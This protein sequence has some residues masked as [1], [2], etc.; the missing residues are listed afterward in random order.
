MDIITGYLGEAHVTAEQDR[1]VNIGVVGD[2]SYVMPAGQRLAAEVQT[3]N[4]VRIRDGVLIHQGCAASIKKNT[5][6]TVTIA[7]G[8]QGM[9][10]IDLIVARYQRNVETGVESLDLIALQGTPAESDPAVP[11]HTEGDIQAGDAVA[12][13]P[14][15]EVEKDGLNITRVTKVFEEVESLSSLNGKMK[16]KL[17]QSITGS[18]VITLPD[19]YDELLAIAIADSTDNYS[20]YSVQIPH[21]LLSAQQEWHRF[22]AGSYSSTAYN[23]E[24][25]VRVK[26]ESMQLASFYINGA[27]RVDTCGLRVYYR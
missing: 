14:L 23:S 15:Y 13:M 25:V 20:K 17:L 19:N 16:W 2:G 7:N 11:K 26:E 1:D 3:N 18:G 8:S 27:N 24:A 22:K 6:D 9:K 5:Y 10:R 4:E 12:D 21:D